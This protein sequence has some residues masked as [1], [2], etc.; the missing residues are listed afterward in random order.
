M[1]IDSVVVISISAM[2]ALVCFRLVL[3]T[4]H[5]ISSDTSLSKAGVFSHIILV[6]LLSVDAFSC[7]GKT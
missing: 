4:H 3:C 7:C 5:F 2:F 6:V 1:W